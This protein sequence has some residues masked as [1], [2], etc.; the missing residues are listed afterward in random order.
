MM[1]F[2][3][4]FVILGAFFIQLLTTGGPNQPASHDG[5][6]LLFAA[7]LF[8]GFSLFITVFVIAR[9]IH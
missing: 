7:V 9:V 3:L 1:I 4:G 8:G 2:L 6:G 5:G